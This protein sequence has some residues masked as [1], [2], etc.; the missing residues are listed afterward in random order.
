M[1][2]LWVD[3]ADWHHPMQFEAPSAQRCALRAQEVAK[4]IHWAEA[5]AAAG[6]WVAG[7][8]TYEA[9][10]AW[11]LP[12]KLDEAHTP[13][14]WFGRFAAPQAACYPHDLGWHSA[15]WQAEI[16]KAR[17]EADLAAIL[18][19]IEAG[20]SYQVNHTL[21]GEITTDTTLQ[22][23][24]M[25]RQQQYRFPYALYLEAPHRTI[26]SLSPELFFHR[27]GD[28][29]TTGP[30][31]G[32]RTRRA[33]PEQDWAMAHELEGS[34]K[35]QAEHVMIVDMARNDLGQ[36][37]QTGTIDVPQLMARRS[38]ATVHH[39]ESRVEGCLRE[40]S[41]L[42]E[43][44]AALF[45]AASITGA[46]KRRTMEI[47]QQLEGSPRSLYCGAVGV[48]KPGGEA[49]FNVAIRTLE[50]R[51]KGPPQV[52]LG[53]GIVADSQ[54]ELEW[55]ELGHKGQF[56]T[57]QQPQ[58]QQLGLIET[59]RLEADGT[60]AWLERH[61]QRLAQSCR[62]LGIPYNQQE[63][64]QA[65][66]SYP[67][68]ELANRSEP[69]ILRLQYN[70]NGTLA[71]THRALKRQPQGVRLMLSPWQVDRGDPLLQH[72]TTRRESLNHLVAMAQ[73]LGCED[74][75]LTNT[76]GQITECAMRGLMVKQQGRWQAPPMCD[77]R[78]KSL[79]LEA[80]EQEMTL[81]QGSFT[82]AELKEAEALQVGN[83]IYGTQQV[84]ELIDHKGERLR[85][86]DALG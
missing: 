71:L 54:A 80:M 70:T 49:L 42:T 12:V 6:Y 13:L 19:W 63:V 81:N 30:I 2:P 7:Y 14:A 3:F 51:T 79:W 75:L 11:E 33:D 67:R 37:C 78:Q 76:A 43:I 46:P 52:G 26:A 38:Y 72:K 21:R 32:T 73:K 74:V 84:A 15:Q 18:Q 9:A 82:L 17:Y 29:L 8:V 69:S 34:A 59:M 53:G 41:S 55:Q 28:R 85:V 10:A 86:Y 45:P 68:R 65:I 24:F 57:Q 39:L 48:I 56:L 40:Q 61:L 77:G 4:V 36:V 83:A 25:Q 66:K 62:A 35:D 27:Q 47:I 31:K 58:T 20:D 1:P 50:Q 23:L 16:S 60:I 22:Q 64:L 44:F 5:Q